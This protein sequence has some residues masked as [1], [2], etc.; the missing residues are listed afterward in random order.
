MCQVLFKNS[1]FIISLNPN[2]LLGTDYYPHFPDEKKVQS[3]V[4]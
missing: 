1:L 4:L 3:K 2:N